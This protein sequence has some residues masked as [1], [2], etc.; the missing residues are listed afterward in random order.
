MQG[1]HSNT[2]TKM[3]DPGLVSYSG[4]AVHKQENKI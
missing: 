1:K 4:L 2:K 3:L